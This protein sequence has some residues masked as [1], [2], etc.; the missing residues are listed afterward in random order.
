MELLIVSQ[1]ISAST[2]YG[3]GSN[4]TGI[5]T[6]SWDGIF[7]GSAIISGSLNVTNSITA[8]SFVGNLIGTSSVAI[9]ASYALSSA[10]AGVPTSLAIAYSIA[11][12]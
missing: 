12:G 6:G 8:S 10:D 9:T 3:D 4:L 11:L 1:S 2:Y 5:N 7:T